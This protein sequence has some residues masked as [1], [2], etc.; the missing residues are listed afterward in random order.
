MGETTPKSTLPLEARGPHLTMNVWGDLTHH[1]K[2]QFDRCMH[3]RTTMQQSHSHGFEHNRVPA[4][5]ECHL[6]RTRHV[7][8]QQPRL[9]PDEL[10]HLGGPAL[11]VVC[12]LHLPKITEFYLCIQ[13]LPAKL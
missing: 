12:S 4:A 10:Y 7:A 9:K 1:P 3:F 8:T 11:L 5:S 2:R 13:M 6:H